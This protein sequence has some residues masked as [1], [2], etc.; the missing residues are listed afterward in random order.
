MGNLNFDYKLFWRHAVAQLVEA[1]DY[2]KP[3]GHK[4]HSIWCHCNVLL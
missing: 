2:K 3:E 4:F 1:L